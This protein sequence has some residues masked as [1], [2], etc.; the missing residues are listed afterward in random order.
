MNLK[1]HVAAASNLVAV[2]SLSLLAAQAHAITPEPENLQS[3]GPIG[4]IIF[5]VLFL[6]FCIG[7]VWMM[8]KQKDPGEKQDGQ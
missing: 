4:G 3:V 1:R 8:K 5:G 2:A 6:G 7:V